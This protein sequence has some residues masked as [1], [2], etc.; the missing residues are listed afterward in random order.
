MLQEEI[1]TRFEPDDFSDSD[2][3][4]ADGTKYFTATI[5]P[6]YPS[7]LDLI[8]IQVTDIPG[9]GT[10]TYTVEATMDAGATWFD[11]TNDWY[12]SA[13]FTTHFT[14]SAAFPTPVDD[15][16]VKRVRTGDAAPGDGGSAV[17][18]RRRRFSI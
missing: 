5:D 16:R 10:N 18:I 9:T 4:Q 12:G 11:V 17:R 15:I 1:A 3:T 7:Q 6:Q 2:A 13:N 14:K 8:F